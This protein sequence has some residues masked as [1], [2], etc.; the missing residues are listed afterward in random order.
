[1]NAISLNVIDTRQTVLLYACCLSKNKITSF[2]FLSCILSLFTRVLLVMS[3]TS[4]LVTRIPYISVWSLRQWRT[5]FASY[6]K[7]FRLLATV[8]QI[9]SLFTHTHT[10]Q[11][12]VLTKFQPLPENGYIHFYFRVFINQS[13]REILYPDNF[14]DSRTSFI[15]NIK[16]RCFL[17]S[18]ICLAV[19]KRP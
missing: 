4:E 11:K 8:E 18:V 17:F 2:Q 12:K 6:F 10:H 9:I 1:M 19:A 3:I 5:Y 14:N 13:N 16:P 15:N 7:T